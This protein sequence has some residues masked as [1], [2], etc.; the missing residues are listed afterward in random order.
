MRLTVLGTSAAFPGKNSAC[1]GYL[2]QHDGK[3]LVMDLGSG[4]LAN[5]QGFIEMGEIDG[6]MISHLHA[7]HFVDLYL[8]QVYLEVVGG[9]TPVPL[10]LPPGGIE[11]VNSVK[12][13]TKDKFHVAFK[14][15]EWEP[16]TGYE[17]GGLQIETAPTVHAEPTVAM[18]VTA[19]GRS[20]TYTADTGPSEN[21]EALAQDTDLLVAESSWTDRPE[22][23]AVGHLTA[24]EAGKMATAAGA[25]RLMLTHFWPGSDTRIAARLANETY[26]GEVLIAKEG[27]SID[28]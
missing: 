21:I 18:R 11:R 8:L 10:F 15:T 13:R 6:V 17:V 16:E 1:S 9:K 4:V 27:K 25:K 20:L 5:L 24:G 12:P 23:A 2:I 28:V 22:D 14:A 3:N 7:D 19:A 26:K